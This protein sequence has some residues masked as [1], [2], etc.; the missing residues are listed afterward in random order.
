MKRQAF[1]SDDDGDTVHNNNNN[2]NNNKSSKND[3]AVVMDGSQG[4]GGGQILR[5]SVAYA[6][7][8]QRPLRIHS[9]RAKRRNPGLQ[10]QHCAAIGLA[11]ELGEGV[12]EGAT[13]KNTEITYHPPSTTD[14][15]KEE[16]ERT[17]EGIVNTAG[18]ICLL[19]QAALPCALLGSNQTTKLVLKGGT[20]AK[21]APQ[22]D[23]WER[24]FLPTFQQWLGGADKVPIEAT[25]LKRGYYPK[26]GGHIEVTVPSLLPQLPIPPLQLTDRGTVKH[27]QIRSFHAGKLP[28][29]LATKMAKSAQQLLEQTFEKDS[30]QIDLEI[31][32]EPNAVGSGLGILIVATTTTGCRLGG[33]A[34]CDPKQ[35]ADEAGRVAAQEL[36]DTWNDGGCVDEWMQDQLILFMAFA[37]GTSTMLTGS[38]TLHTQ[39]AIE[40]AQQMV[41]GVKFDVQRLEEPAA[42]SAPKSDGGGYGSDGRISGKHLITCHGIGY[43]GN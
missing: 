37:K 31:V 28:R 6:S 20:N 30:I 12:L 17:V 34:L 42:A 27:I 15:P 22:Y 8:L 23:Y 19:L 35:K 32:T 24:I 9:I 26:G 21:M 18:S 3:M 14:D 10:A 29:H 36:V 38:L 1:P 25:V 11:A 13:L 7:I 39:T 5:N 40:V 33:S 41:P 16:E 4:E 2:N 43:T